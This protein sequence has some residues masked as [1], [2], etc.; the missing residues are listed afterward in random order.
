MNRMRT[1][2][3]GPS[4]LI[5]GHPGHELRLF[6]WLESARPLVFVLTDGSGSGRVRTGS[7]IELIQASGSSA[8]PVMG[9]FTDV[10]IY[11]AMMQKDVTRV[12][13][14]T[15]TIAESL[16]AKGIRSVVADAFELY[17]PT[18]DLCSV[19]ATLAAARAQAVAGIA[20]ARY[21]Y[22]VTQAAL[23]GGIVF[24][25]EPADV[26]RKMAAAYRFENLTSDV[27]ALLAAVGHHEV[28]R[29][30]LRP[31]ANVVALP[32]PSGKPHYEVHGEARVASGRYR[33]VLRYEEH[34]VPFVRALEA[35]LG[36]PVLGPEPATTYA[37]G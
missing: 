30:M 2:P 14:V 5:V 9:A 36:I 18:H 34:F 7:S 6:R 20:I 16:V 1:N 12:V 29:E 26:E 10:E 19:V 28:A 11:E 17:N 33:T 32:A 8:G 31:V 37:P 24:D 4:A 21:D 15:E 25:L 13:A 35:A 27:D 3:A 22:P 23:G